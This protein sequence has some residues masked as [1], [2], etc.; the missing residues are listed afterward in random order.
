MW[1]NTN[2]TAQLLARLVI[3][4]N[5]SALILHTMPGGD[6]QLPQQKAAVPFNSDKV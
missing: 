6:R 2:R 1:A 4:R 3:F 5:W